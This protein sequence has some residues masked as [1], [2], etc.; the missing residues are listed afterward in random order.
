MMIIPADPFSADMTTVHTTSLAIVSTMREAAESADL[1]N[2]QIATTSRTTSP[3]LPFVSRSSSSPAKIS[4]NRR[5]HFHRLPR[6]TSPPSRPIAG[7]RGLPRFRRRRHCYEVGEGREDRRRRERHCSDSRSNDH[8]AAATESTRPGN[9]EADADTAFFWVFPGSPLL[10]AMPLAP[11]PRARTLSSVPLPPAHI[12]SLLP[13]LHPPPPRHLLPSPLRFHSSCSAFLFSGLPPPS[14]LLLLA[15]TDFIRAEP[16]LTDLTTVDTTSLTN[17]S[18]M[19]EER[20]CWCVSLRRPSATSLFHLHLLFPR[21]FRVVLTR[22][23]PASFRALLLFHDFPIA[24]FAAHPSLPPS[25][26]T[27]SL[28]ASSSAHTPSHPIHSH[29][30]ASSTLRHVTSYLPSSP[31]QS[32]A[33]L[34]LPSP[35]DFTPRI[36]SRRAAP[37]DSTVTTPR[38]SSASPSSS[39][40]SP[41]LSSPLASST[42][43]PSHSVPVPVRPRL[44]RLVSPPLTLRRTP[45]SCLRPI[46][47]PP[48]TSLPPRASHSPPLT[49]IPLRVEKMKNK[50]IKLTGEVQQVAGSRTSALEANE[51]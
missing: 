42:P 46:I 31:F 48:I 36:T 20:G 39:S 14:S 4:S 34:L 11:A 26:Y 24:P 47:L 15:C 43:R 16:L 40:P 5:C 28:R 41:S 44:A 18:T 23:L 9:V 13:P 6:P 7:R 33:L 2:P 29:P 35:A 22:I 45:H 51:Q 38:P 12:P 21:L 37:V 50:V 3:S 32:P 10:R 49:L 30:I 8:G 27:A 1:Y 19:H 25:P 17:L